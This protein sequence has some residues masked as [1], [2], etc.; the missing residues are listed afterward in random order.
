MGRQ[1]LGQ[2]N[3]MADPEAYSWIRTNPAYNAWLSGTDSNTLVVAG[4]SGTGVSSLLSCVMSFLRD[5][6]PGC[7]VIHFSFDRRNPGQCS[8]I[9]MFSALTLQLLLA[10]PPR[11]ARVRYLFKLI[12]DKLS[13]SLESLW[14][15]F[16]TLLLIPRQEPVFC[17]IDGSGN[18]NNGQNHFL[19]DFFAL[20]TT[21]EAGVKIALTSP[22]AALTG[23]ASRLIIDLNCKHE[24]RQQLKKLVTERVAMLVRNDPAF[25]DENNKTEKR[26]RENMLRPGAIFLTATLAFRWLEDLETRSTPSSIDEAVES[27]PSSL[28]DIYRI[29]LLP[30]M[31][32]GPTWIRDAMRL[33]VFALRPLKVA[34]LSAAICITWNDGNIVLREE[35]IPRNLSKDLERV[36]GDI[37]EIENDEVFL[38]HDSLQKLLYYSRDEW[39]IPDEEGLVGHARLAHM[40]IEYLLHIQVPEL[41]EQL[42]GTSTPPA[43]VLYAGQYWARHYQ[44]AEKSTLRERALKLLS[45]KRRVEMCHWAYRES[46]S[47]VF[48]SSITSTNPILVAAILGLRDIVLSELSQSSFET[49]IESIVLF[50]ASEQGD[51]SIA[52]HLVKKL[53]PIKTGWANL[54]VAACRGHMNIVELFLTAG[55][56]ADVRDS[57]GSTPLLLAAQSGYEDIVHRLLDA[58]SDINAADISDRTA[59]HLSAEYGHDNVVNALV[60]RGAKVGATDNELSTPLH[61]ATKTGQLKVVKSLLSNGAHADAKDINSYTPLHI[62]AVHGLLDTVAS[63]R[64]QM[65]ELTADGKTALHLAVE[66]GHSLMIPVLLRQ[67]AKLEAG[68]KSN[69][70][71]ALHVA[72]VKG[73]SHIAETILTFGGNPN[74]EDAMKRSP[75]HLAASNGHERIIKQ[76]LE[77]GGD[78]RAMD[79]TG[80]SP[81]H[82]AAASGHCGTIDKLINSA[83]MLVSLADYSGLTPLHKAAARGNLES[84]EILLNDRAD[85]DAVSD[86]G[87]PL[88]YAIQH[89]GDPKVVKFLLRQGSNTEVADQSGRR[90]LHVAAKLGNAKIVRLLIDCA[91]LDST[92]NHDITPLM[93]AVEQGSILVVQELLD[94]GANITASNLDGATPLHLAVEHGHRDIVGSILRQD[95]VPHKFTVRARNTQGHIPLHIAAQHGAMDIV[96][97]LLS[98]RGD[99]QV[100]MTDVRERTPLHYAVK[101]GHADVVRE[102]IKHGADG[103]CVD[104]EGLTPLHMAARAGYVEIAVLLL[105]VDADPNAKDENGY[106]SLHHAIMAGEAEMVR[107]LC[108]WKADIH[109]ETNNRQSVLHLAT[110]SGNLDLVQWFKNQGLDPN[111]ITNDNRTSFSLAAENGRLDILN[112]LGPVSAF[113][114]QPAELRGPLSFAAQNGHF[115]IVDSLLK[116]GVHPDE[117]I[118]TS[119]ASPID[120]PLMYAVQHEHAEVA[121]LL[122][123]AGANLNFCNRED[124]TPFYWAVRNGQVDLINKFMEAEVDIDAS[125]TWPALYTGAYYGQSG[126]VQLLLKKNLNVEKCG[127]NEWTP[128]HAAFDNSQV[129]KILLAAGAQVDPENRERFTPLNLAAWYHHSDTIPVL[130]EYSANPVHQTEYGDTPFHHLIDDEYVSIVQEMLN[131]AKGSIDIE[132]DYGCTPLWLAVKNSSVKMVELLLTK[133]EVDVNQKNGNQTLLQLAVDTENLTIIQLLLSRWAIVLDQSPSL[134]HAVSARG[135]S[136][137]VRILLDKGVDPLQ[138]DEFGWSAELHA[139]AAGQEEVIQILRAGDGVNEIR[140]SKIPPPFPPTAFSDVAKSECCVLFDDNLVVRHEY[141]GSRRKSLRGG[142]TSPSFTWHAYAHRPI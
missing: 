53:V 14:A 125:E 97:A 140:R 51:E 48:S 35:D 29:C 40:C 74:A 129:S 32:D 105:N 90:P 63:F 60:E 57:L 84:I 111:A 19:A 13:W 117:G 102:L 38:V 37:I 79:V 112:A 67:G 99:R 46:A 88:H 61:L 31:R 87:S 64:G 108:D 122:L 127:P 15:F 66:K 23:G 45:E 80:S 24:H 43:L 73:F 95:H 78:S 77:A 59:L 49:D 72:S 42:E 109:I 10:D 101:K 28:S 26:I 68:A 136:D 36:F 5:E 89:N 86:E 93:L 116:S 76:L 58:G 137:L 134:L 94:H 62:A 71:T 98:F 17:F 25:R 39:D 91:E 113:P 114:I 21:P 110:I 121:R 9:A 44:L 3:H 16:R 83:K 8:T 7:T 75:L 115:A 20:A 33:I 4:L 103:A 130:L 27:I 56:D 2:H 55:V 142:F 70:G 47:S 82:F 132:D 100:K 106:T 107:L 81:L 119:I 118:D 139:L 141:D 126:V 96:T 138:R 85:I 135:Y 124:E 22:D 104:F 92:D 131:I 69:V 128:L 52:Q 34:E 54:H 11:F 133:G 41:D 123:E 50:F 1:L 12:D 30:I 18:C 120:T 65:D 6:K